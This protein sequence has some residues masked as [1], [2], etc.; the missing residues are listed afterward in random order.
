MKTMC[1]IT[2]ALLL[3]GCASAPRVAV[4][5][6]PAA[7]RIIERGPVT[8]PVLESAYE[9]PRNR[10][11]A[12]AA[13]H[14]TENGSGRTRELVL[15]A[16]RQIGVPYRYGGSSPQRGFDCSGLVRY[17]YKQ[18]GIALPRTTESMSTI[19]LRV[20]K[21]EIEP[22]DLVFFDT[23]RKPFSHV[24]IYVGERRFI[25]APASGGVVELVDMRA[26]YW[27]TRYV[28]ARRVVF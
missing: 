22:G 28:G 1:S 9:R 16:R 10:E 20:R 14:A 23:G 6:S 21:G 17:V 5:R 26:R 19:G 12:D 18:A 15:Q 7:P 4:E 27:H 11:Q 25:H 8:P 24:G 13:Q 3:A 2:A